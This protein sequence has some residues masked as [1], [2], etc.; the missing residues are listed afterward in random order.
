MVKWFN[1][2][3]ERWGVHEILLRAASGYAEALGSLYFPC[4]AQRL[5]LR[6]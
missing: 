4:A 6:Q 1:D 5:A 2:T 3:Q